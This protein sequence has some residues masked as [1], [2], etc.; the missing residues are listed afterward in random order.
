MTAARPRRRASPSSSTCTRRGGGC[1]SRERGRGRRREAAWMR[2]AA[3]RSPPPCLGRARRALGSR[4]TTTPRVVADGFHFL[5]GPRWRD[6][7]LWVSDMHGDRVLAVTPGGAVEPI[8][9][10][11]MQPSG[12][13]WLP[14]GRLLV[15]SMTNRRLLRLEGGRLM[16]HAD[17]SGI[18]T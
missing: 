3:A 10:V 14:D 7:R 13:G 8:V 15:V 16:V 17:L 6:G 11:P 2:V 1:R 18:A 9:E 4:M 12:L 5:E